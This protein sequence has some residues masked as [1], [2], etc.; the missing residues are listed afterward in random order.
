MI[1]DEDFD[2]EVESSRESKKYR[3]QALDAAASR[4]MADVEE[5]EI[6]DGR[7]DTIPAELPE[8]SFV[9]PADVVSAIGSGSTDAGFRQLD[10]VFSEFVGGAFDDEPGVEPGPVDAMI[11]D[12]EYIVPPEAVAAIGG[13]DPEMGSQILESLMMEIR[14]MGGA[15]GIAEMEGGPPAGMGDLAGGPPP[16]GDMSPGAFDDVI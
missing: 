5:P 8:G 15:T 11:S 16:A 3:D 14:D 9:L 4:G 10:E 6:H 1:D 2:V 12:G 7:S 13:G